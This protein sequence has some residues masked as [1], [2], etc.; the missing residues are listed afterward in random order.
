M[1]GTLKLTSTEV[2]RIATIV[3]PAS[4]TPYS[5]A[6]KSAITSQDTGW[7]R[8]SSDTATGSVKADTAFGS[9]SISS[10]AVRLAGSA[11]TDARVLAA[12]TCAGSAAFANCRSVARPETTVT[13]DS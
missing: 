1:P 11:A 8:R 6:A 7:L 13:T 10:A 3:A 4:G 12:T 2:T 9:L 5:F